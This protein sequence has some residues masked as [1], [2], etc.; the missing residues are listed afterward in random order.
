MSEIKT[1]VR[2]VLSLICLFGLVSGQT[3]LT[4]RQ[5]LQ[6]QRQQKQVDQ[7]QELLE[8]QLLSQVGGVSRRSLSSLWI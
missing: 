4:R 8:K 1:F 2:V 7:Q 5:Q 3:P 6:L